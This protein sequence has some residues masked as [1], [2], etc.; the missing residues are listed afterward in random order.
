[1]ALSW[2]HIAIV[3]YADGPEKDRARQDRDRLY[4]QL[5]RREK[6]RA[7][8]IA[9]VWLTKKGEGHLLDLSLD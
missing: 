2:L 9:R 4:T 1:M 5:T 7:M 3:H 8:D 6:D